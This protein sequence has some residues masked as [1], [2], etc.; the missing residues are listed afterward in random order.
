M[1]IINVYCIKTIVDEEGFRMDI[2]IYMFIY[3]YI[4]QTIEDEE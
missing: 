4:V 3:I 2:Y 1:D